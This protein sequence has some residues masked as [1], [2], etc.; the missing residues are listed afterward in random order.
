[1]E[2]IV[3]D[4]ASTD[5]TP[6]IC[7]RLPGIRFI[8]LRKNVGLAMARN[9][10]I[11]ASSAEYV[12]FLDDDDIRLPGSLDLQIEALEANPQAGFCTGRILIGDG[13]CNPTDAVYP[14][15]SPHGDVFWAF[16]EQN[17]ILV[18]GAVVRRACLDRVGH[19]HP[20]PQGEDWDLWIRLAEHY[21]AVGV[22]PP[23]GIV[24]KG[25]RSSGQMTSNLVRHFAIL[26]Q[27]QAQ[28]LKLPR[29]LEAPSTR[30]REIRRR[31]L[32]LLCDK[33]I[34]SAATAINER[35][36]GYARTNLLAA[37]RL[38]F[39]RAARPWTF[40][41]LLQSFLPLT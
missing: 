10:G 3:V 41:L 22:D 34:L 28:A 40:K 26:A 6:R 33:L 18:H 31:F 2:I 12:S 25:T 38:R 4:D 39:C 27:V 29:A 5:D 19:F 20:F 37:L 30:R 36:R 9:C 7:E 1:M 23:V 17:Q 14:D 16:L 11:S 15:R 21:A 32:N 35:D 24:R 13:D 8:R